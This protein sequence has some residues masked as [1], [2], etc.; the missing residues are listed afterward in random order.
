MINAGSI[1]EYF[2]RLKSFWKVL[3]WDSNGLLGGTLIAWNHHV[4]NLRDFITVAGILVEGFTHVFSKILRILN[5]Y[6]PYSKR[7]EFWEEIFIL[8]FWQIG[9]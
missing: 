5:I 7:L 6:A 3:A 9:L 2:V 1:C 8:E 4:A